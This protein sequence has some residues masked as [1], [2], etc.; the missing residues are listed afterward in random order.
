MEQQNMDFQAYWT[1]TLIEIVQLTHQDLMLVTFVLDTNKRK[2]FFVTKK[3]G[4]EK[5]S[6]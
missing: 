6:S 4:N 3:E 5:Y 1:S 2:I